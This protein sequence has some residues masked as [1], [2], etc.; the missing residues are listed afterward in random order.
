MH[1][2][3]RLPLALFFTEDLLHYVAT[4]ILEPL[5]KTRKVKQ[6]VVEIKAHY[7]ELTKVIGTKKRE[8]AA[9]ALIV[10]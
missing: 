6:F 7:T 9:V 8:A 2:K 10:L 4:D 3:L 5:A 1:N